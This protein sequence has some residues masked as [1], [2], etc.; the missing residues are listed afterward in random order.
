[1]IYVL[2]ATALLARVADAGCVALA[3]GRRE[4]V[5]KGVAAAAVG[6]VF[7]AEELVGRT[8]RVGSP[9]GAEPVMM[10]EDIHVLVGHGMLTLFSSAAS[11]THCARSTAR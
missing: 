8:L 5:L 3:V 7:E 11:L 10:S 9:P 6:S 1:M 4:I 2:H